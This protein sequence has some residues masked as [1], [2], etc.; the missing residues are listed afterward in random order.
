MGVACLLSFPILTQRPP[1][2][3]ETITGGGQ[4]LAATPAV[5]SL[6]R[7]AAAAC[8]LSAAR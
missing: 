5:E 1:R 4:V 2:L 8:S 3:V 7:A 6:P